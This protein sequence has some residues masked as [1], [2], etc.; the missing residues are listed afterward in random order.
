MW[1]KLARNWFTPNSSLL[2]SRLNPHEVSDDWEK[3]LPSGTTVVDEK[4]N[5]VKSVG[6]PDDKRLDELSKKPSETKTEAKK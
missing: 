3:L 1:I 4:G 2:E 6:E 5:E